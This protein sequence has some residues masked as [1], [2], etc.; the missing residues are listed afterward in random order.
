MRNWQLGQVRPASNDCWSGTL[1]V[2]RQQ[3]QRQL[4]LGL[5]PLLDSKQALQRT[6]VGMGIVLTRWALLQCLCSIRVIFDTRGLCTAR[7]ELCLLGTLT[8]V[9]L[10][11]RPVVRPIVCVAV[12][13][14]SLCCVCYV[15]VA[16]FVLLLC[17][18]LLHFQHRWL[19]VCCA[20]QVTAR[21]Q[22]TD[23]AHSKSRAAAACWWVVHVQHLEHAQLHRAWCMVESAM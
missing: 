14:R 1:S 21:L 16:V 12:G 9:G 4:Q 20:W 19:G 11:A 8:A 10:W 6:T 3:R 13:T 15:C 23:K 5:P 2:H 22:L 17:C 7:V 18:V